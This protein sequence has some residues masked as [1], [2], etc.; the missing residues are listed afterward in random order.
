MVVLV[1]GHETF[2]PCV[3]WSRL[4]VELPG[5]ALRAAAW[6]A[7]NDLQHAIDDAEADPVADMA[8]FARR[9]QNVINACAARW[10][11]CLRKRH[12]RLRSRTN[13]YATFAPRLL[14]P[15]STA[16]GSPY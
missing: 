14:E 2:L 15:R 6:L 11:L 7:L 9:V 12:N 8:W 4:N 13:W 1:V 3:T 10:R 16:A 5:V